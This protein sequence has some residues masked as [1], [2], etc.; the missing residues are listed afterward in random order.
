MYN[1]NHEP[2]YTME[3]IYQL[4][5]FKNNHPTDPSKMP[6]RTENKRILIIL[7]LIKLKSSSL[8]KVVDFKF[9]W[10]WYFMRADDLD[11]IVHGNL[12]REFGWYSK[13]LVVC[14]W[15][16]AKGTNCLR[17][18]GFYSFNWQGFRDSN[19]ISVCLTKSEAGHVFNFCWKKFNDWWFEIN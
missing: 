16:D 6:L 2:K 1:T 9:Q 4:L 19:Q 14:V 11:T 3:V 7:S 15:A 10:E 18:T 17:Q 5:M 12:Y 8:W 13:N